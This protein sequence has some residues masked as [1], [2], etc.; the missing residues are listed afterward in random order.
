MKKLLA[1]A[2]AALITLSLTGC[3][4]NDQSKPKTTVKKDSA[5]VYL[6]T[7]SEPRMGFDPMKGFANPDGIS[8]FHS[9]LLKLNEDLTFE[10]EVAQDYKISEDGLTYTFTLKDIKCSDGQPLTAEDVKFS[11]ETAAKNPRVGNLGDIQ[12]IE[13]KNAKEVVFHMKQPN[14]LFLYTIARL[15]IVPKHAYKEG[16]GQMPIGS[17]PYKMVKWDKGQQMVVEANE[18]YFKG[19][20]KLKKITF[21]FV[22]GEAAY[23]A[24]KAGNVDLYDTPYNYANSPVPGTT[25][26]D[27]KSVGKFMMM[28]PVNKPGAV[29]SADKRPTGNKVTSDVAVRKALNLGIN[30]SAIVKNLMYGHGAPA[31]EL[32]DPEVPYYNPETAYKDNDIEAAKKL[33][34]DAGWKDTNGNG[35]VDKDGQEAD[36]ELLVDAKDK[37]LQNIGILLADQSKK[38][39]VNII[40][41]PK[42]AEECTARSCETPWLINFGSLDPMNVYYIYYGPNSGKGF[43]NLSYLQNKTVDSYIEK[44]MHAPNEKVANENWKKAQWDGK[45]GFSV[46]GEASAIWLVNKNYMYQ[47]KKGFS[48]GKQQKLQP[49]SMGWCVARNIEE[50]DWNE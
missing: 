20:P 31:Y 28:L 33:L 2:M 26:T 13:V 49:G 18:Y 35:I 6:G 9:N 46:K 34:A 29:K 11:F 3:G 10:K 30:R 14:S 4:G 1:G 7:R 22:N 47:A 39:G 21:L 45:T 12:N 43:Y 41:S 16:Y 38:F 5:V 24:A 37:M 15:P 40:L 36:I 19:K 23:Q 48:M 44:A 50:W 17:G 27:Y 32:A 8:I 25:M 42:S